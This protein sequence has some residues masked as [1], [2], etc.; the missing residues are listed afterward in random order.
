M[1]RPFQF[2]LDLFRITFLKKLFPKNIL[3]GQT[4]PLLILPVAS[5]SLSPTLMTGRCHVTEIL[6]GGDRSKA[7][8]RSPAGIRLRGA[9]CPDWLRPR[10]E[11]RRISANQLQAARDRQQRN[12][13]R[14]ALAGL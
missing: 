3:P 4:R 7:W 10:S 1:S 6:A 9:R 12:S 14:P 2:L 11:Q 5:G 13:C 8:S